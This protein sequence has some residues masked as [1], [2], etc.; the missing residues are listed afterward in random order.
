MLLL[1]RKAGQ[2]VV[3]QCKENI[4]VKVLCEENG[5]VTLGFDAPKNIDVDREEVYREKK[6][7]RFI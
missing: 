2:S 4:V 7:L 3:I 6:Q 5:V 1:R